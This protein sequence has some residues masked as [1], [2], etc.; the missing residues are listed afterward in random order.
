M[1]AI[2]FVVDSGITLGLVGSG[3]AA[4][5]HARVIA[6]VIGACVTW[7]LNRQFTF[8]AGGGWKRW[9]LYVAF[10]AVG[11]LMNVGVYGLWVRAH[12]TGSVDL[13]AGILC[14]ALLALAFNFLVSKYIVFQLRRGA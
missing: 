3:L 5:L 10:T 11:A 14:G 7:S 1:G 2:G 8:R 13:L 4:P 9:S 12:G 6:F